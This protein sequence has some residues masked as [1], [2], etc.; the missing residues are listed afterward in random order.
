MDDRPSPSP[1]AIQYNLQPE[2]ES[3]FGERDR[4]PPLDHAESSNAANGNEDKHITM[5]TPSPG[6]FRPSLP[7]RFSA[8]EQS[9]RS[10]S[11][12]VRLAQSRA[13]QEQLLGDDELADDDGCYPPRKDS[14]P[15][16]PNPHRQLPIYTTIHRIRRLVIACIGNSL[17]AFLARYGRL[18]VCRRSVQS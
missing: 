1:S 4:T 8:R 18:I 9:A 16:Q 6:Q 13:E 10:I 3:P 15:W 17:A 2:G 11:E 14:I 12:A 5:S 7:D